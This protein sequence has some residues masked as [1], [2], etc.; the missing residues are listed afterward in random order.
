MRNAFSL[1]RNM[2]QHLPIT[3]AISLWN[4]YFG[5][6]WIYGKI[7]PAKGSK[8]CSVSDDIT[9]LPEPLIISY[10]RLAE[11]KT[12]HKI[13]GSPYFL[14]I[15]NTFRRIRKPIDIKRDTLWQEVYSFKNNS[16]DSCEN[17]F[18]PKNKKSIN[19]VWFCFRFRVTKGYS[20]KMWS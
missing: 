20:K 17:R 8:F 16:Q 11:K 4:M 18:P 2:L 13:W 12:D 15:N 3:L 1:C 5:Q 19:T 10:Q 6:D 9:T 7:R 14:K